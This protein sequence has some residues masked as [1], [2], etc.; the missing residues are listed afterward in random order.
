MIIHNFD[1]IEINEYEGTNI[2]IIK[3]L[4]DNVFCDKFVNIIDEF[5]NNKMG[6]YE[7]NII[8]GY[9]YMVNKESNKDIDFEIYK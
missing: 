8:N 1:N 3:N 2:Y 7:N 6:N 5:E 4:I 9:Q